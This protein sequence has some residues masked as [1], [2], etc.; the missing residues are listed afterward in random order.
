MVDCAMLINVGAGCWYCGW[1]VAMQNEC[2][3][4]WGIEK[5]KIS[6]NHSSHRMLDVFVNFF[7]ISISRSFTEAFLI[8][9]VRFRPPII[10]FD[11]LLE[12]V[13]ISLEGTSTLVGLSLSNF[14]NSFL[15]LPRD[16]LLRLALSRELSSVVKVSFLSKL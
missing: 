15:V 6:I 12:K 3:R 1:Q 4:G 13:D 11:V 7:W 10:G 2:G 9:E 16:N 8:R 14:Y 5:I